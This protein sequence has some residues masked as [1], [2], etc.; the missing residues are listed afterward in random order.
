MLVGFQ[1][2]LWVAHI[3]LLDVGRVAL[4]VVHWIFFVVVIVVLLVY[5][6]I[7]GFV[8]ENCT[9]VCSHQ[10]LW[11]PSNKHHYISYSF[12]SVT[13][14]FL[15]SV[16]VCY[17]PILSYCKWDQFLNQDFLTKSRQCGGHIDAKVGAELSDI[18]TSKVR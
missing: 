17:L 18:I 13:Y 9:W 6:C 2:Q 12:F 3:P 14:Q 10:S 8:V 16:L 1:N 11:K 15:I 7:R 5:K 4:C